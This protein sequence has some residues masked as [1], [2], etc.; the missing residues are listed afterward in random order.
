MSEPA[1]PARR[2]AA[3]TPARPAYSRDYWDLVFA[4]VRRKPT[5]VGS[6][7]ALVLLY[8]VAIFAPFLANDRPLVLDATDAS[9]YRRARTSLTPI[10]LNLRGMLVDGRAA[11]EQRRAERA[12]ALAQAKQSEEGAGLPE[13]DA[14]LAAEGAALTQRTATMRGQLAASDHAPLDALDAAVEAI[15][16][17]AAAGRDDQAQAAAEDLVAAARRVKDELVIAGTGQPAV[18]G[19]TV[20]L[21]PSRSYP[22]L[23]ALGRGEV[24]F[25]GLWLLL[26]TWPLWNTVVNRLVLGGDLERIRH[27]RRA[28]VL[29]TLLLPALVLPFWET[30]PAA[31]QMAAYK[32]GLTNGDIQADAVTFPPVAFGLAEVND[33]E[34]F[35]APTWHTSSEITE[36]GYYAR[37]ARAENIGA[38]E[39]FTVKPKPVVVAAGEPERNAPLRH[40]LG[41]DSLGRDLLARIIWGARVSL[42]VGLVSTVLLVFIGVLLGS[43]AGFYGG[44]IDVIISRVIEVVQCFPVFFLILIWVAFTQQTGIVPIMVV[45]GIF[46]W[47]GVARLVRGEFIRLRDQDF[48]VASEALGVPDLRTI[49]RHVLPNAMGPVLVA[50]TFAVASGILTESALSFLGFG[51]QLPIP[52]WG[53]IVNETKA[54]EHWWIQIFPGL[55]IF[56]TVMLY[57]LL[58]EGVRDALD[59]RLKKA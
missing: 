34:Y 29:G 26:M 13:W 52:S 33:A 59:P 46:R 3:G 31:G 36:E 55:L 39:G 53:S 58:G 15:L 50:A 1:T 35:R 57:N 2:A 27:A 54:A 18:P 20:Q 40:V 43:L 17:H 7:V 42:S 24:F 41:T 19:E 30:D 12:E 44:W 56:L 37:G 21:V 49:F 16:E 32:S 45:I 28:K 8:A 9:S 5:V 6:L 22:V 14:A 10:S 47:T 25:M 4:Q 51:I 48:V 38:I 11:H 23:A